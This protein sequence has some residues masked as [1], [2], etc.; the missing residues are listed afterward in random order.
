[1]NQAAS[2][3]KHCCTSV[4]PLDVKL[5]RANFRIVVAH[6]R[7]QRNVT[8]LGIVGLR[9]RGETHPRLLHARQY[10]NLEP[11]GGRNSLERR[12]AP[13]RHVGELQILTSRQVAGHPHA[14]LDSD[15][16]QEAEHRSAA[17]LDLHN[18]EP[19]HIAGLN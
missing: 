6:P 18:F 7:V 13:G 9:L 8:R 12:K 16:V 4:L 5:K 1:M 14:G 2:H 15:H 17:V 3:A 11:S 10:H 19:T